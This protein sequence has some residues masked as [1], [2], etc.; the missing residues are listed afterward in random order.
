MIGG[1]FCFANQTSFGA[2]RPPLHKLLPFRR[3][4]FAVAAVFERF[5][6]LGRPWH[7]FERG[8]AR[9]D[10]GDAGDELWVFGIAAEGGED[11]PARPRPMK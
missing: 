10:P 8:A 5:R 4:H 1:R 11:G 7:V 3:R 6:R 2:P 9:V